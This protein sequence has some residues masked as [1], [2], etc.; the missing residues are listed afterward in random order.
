MHSSRTYP[1]TWWS[2]LRTEC[3]LNLRTRT[4]HVRSSLAPRKL[5]LAFGRALTAFRRSSNSRC[6]IGSYTGIGKSTACLWQQALCPRVVRIRCRGNCSFWCGLVCCK[7]GCRRQ[8]I[9]QCLT[10]DNAG[11]A[12]SSLLNAF[13][14]SPFLAINRIAV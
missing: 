4:T 12:W 7:N 9:F 5:R 3:S 13:V 8:Q 14:C 2:R 11:G 10:T 6:D 1:G